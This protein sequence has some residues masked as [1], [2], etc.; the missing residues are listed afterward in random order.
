MELF[1]NQINELIVSNEQSDQ[2]FVAKDRNRPESQ[3]QNTEQNMSFL[4]LEADLDGLVCPHSSCNY[5]SI[6]CIFD[7]QYI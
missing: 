1:Q 2:F 4:E 3:K 5:S 6:F 7:W